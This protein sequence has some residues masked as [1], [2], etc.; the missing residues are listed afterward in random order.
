MPMEKMQYIVPLVTII[1]LGCEGLLCY[2][3]KFDISLEG[4]DEEEMTGESF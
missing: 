1:H 2:S 3:H 4:W